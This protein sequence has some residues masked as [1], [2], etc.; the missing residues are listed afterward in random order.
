MLI[1]FVVYNSVIGDNGKMYVLKQLLPIYKM[2]I[3]PLADILMPNEFEAELL[4]YIMVKTIVLSSIWLRNIDYLL[5][6]ACT[7]TG[8]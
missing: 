8:I 4:T 1:F 5:A 7:E 3:V 6:L 2:T